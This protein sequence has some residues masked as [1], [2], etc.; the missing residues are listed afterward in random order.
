MPGTMA[1]RASIQS[2][3]GRALAVGEANGVEVPGLPARG[4]A[5]KRD[6]LD[7]VLVSTGMALM[8]D[9]DPNVG[10]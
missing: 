9:R 2:F 7:G 5:K 6:E 1:A 10:D 8:G 3:L 4:L